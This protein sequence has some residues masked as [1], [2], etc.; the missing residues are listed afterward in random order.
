MERMEFAGLLTR[1]MNRYDRFLISGHVRP[2]GDAIGSLLALSYALQNNGK[3]AMLVLD[4]DGDRYT[5]ILRPVPALPDD[6]S[7]MDAGKYFQT[8]KDFAFVMLD[9]SDPERTGRAEDAIMAA[10]SSLSI[11]HHVTSVEACNFNYCEPETSSTCEILFNLFNLAGIPIDV[12]IATAL[13]MGVAYDTGGFRHSNTSADA[14]FMASELKKK[15]ADSCFLMNYLFYTEKFEETRCYAAA[16]KNTKIDEQGIL[17]SV[18]SASEFMKL[19]AKS[20]SADGV[21]G[22]LTE[23]EEA[24]VVVFM[25]ELEAGCI[26]VNMRSKCNVNVARVASLFGGGG[27]IKAAGCTMNMPLLTCKEEIVQAIRRQMEENA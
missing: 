14:Y 17:L 21:V 27:H 26:R 1:F 7:V 8:G 19:G 12:D 24:K 18:L 2:D 4:G 20:S 22:K 25:R 9:C 15:G 23:I 3:E 11:D 6:V 13:F 10:V 5:S 16:V